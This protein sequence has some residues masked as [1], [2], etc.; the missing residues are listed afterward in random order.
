MNALDKAISAVGTAADL[1]RAVGVV[2]MAVS[3]WRKRKQVPAERCL[4]IEAA[5]AGK[6]TRYDLRPDIYGKQPQ[7]AAA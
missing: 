3:Q 7:K 2:P 6:V 5:T 1:A 4:Q